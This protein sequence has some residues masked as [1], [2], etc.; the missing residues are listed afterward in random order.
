MATTLNDIHPDI[1]RTHILPRL[2]G[3][4]LSTTATIS[5][6]LRSLCSDDNLWANVSKSI[7]P[8]IQHPCVDNIISTFPAGYRS[9]FQ[10]SFPT[11]ITDVINPH[12]KCSRSISC[13]TDN[14]IHSWPSELISAVD[15][16]YL[17]DI[18]YSNV[19]ITHTTP[20]L[21]S[22]PLLILLKS[23]QELGTSQ[24]G[25]NLNVDERIG[26][27]DVT[28]SHLKEFVTLNWILI[29]P[30]LKRAG[31]LSSI[32]PVRVRNDWMT[33]ET[34]LEYVTV[35]PGCDPN[36]EIVQYKIKVVIGSEGLHVNEVMLELQDFNYSKCLNGSDFLVITQRALLEENNV[37]R[38]VV[39]DEWRL[40]K[41]KEFKEMK[42]ENKKWV[43][44]EEE[45]REFAIEMYNIGILL[46][47]LLSVY[48]LTLL[49][50]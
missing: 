28:L 43:K 17:N 2:D 48:F 20:D 13:D 14:S 4:S 9:F 40:R 18:I 3:T 45:K 38:K 15:I 16:H 6:Y 33:N 5:S 29:D 42:I 22:S 50:R 23:K 12:N 46:T 37:H 39:N 41:Y 25:V 44:N 30:V 31:N 35:L 27:N 1:I 49:L 34:V 8:S 19:Q 36:H 7:W 32:K 26:T 21:L 24:Q 47:F 10:D 11:L